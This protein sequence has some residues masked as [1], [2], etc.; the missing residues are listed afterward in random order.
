MKSYL[1]FSNKNEIYIHNSTTGS[2]LIK[3]QNRFPTTEK[4]KEKGA[5]IAPMPSQVIEILVK[6]NDEVKEGDPL[7]I[8]SSMKMENTICAE[9]DGIIE[10]IFTKEEANIEAGFTLLKIKAN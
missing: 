2:C 5:C 8:L 10:E 3:I 7:A 9:E 1:G 6:V 4:E